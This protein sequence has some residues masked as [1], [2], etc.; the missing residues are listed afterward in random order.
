MSSISPLDGS[1]ERAERFRIE[2][3]PDRERVIVAPHGELDIDTVP[4]VADEIDELAERGFPAIV[5]D[6]RHTTFIDST[7]IH[8]LLRKTARRDVRITVIDGPELVSR[9]FDLAGVRDAL[10]FETTL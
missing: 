5:V 4:A 2:T 1:A 7:G 8:L 10:P 9:V 3:E 6:L